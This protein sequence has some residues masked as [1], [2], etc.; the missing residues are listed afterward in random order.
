MHLGRKQNKK[1]HGC[2]KRET[3]RVYGVTKVEG[4][5]GVRQRDAHKEWPQVIIILVGTNKVLNARTK[6]CLLVVGDNKLQL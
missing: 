4:L 5:Q 2:K 3:C 6:F 1:N